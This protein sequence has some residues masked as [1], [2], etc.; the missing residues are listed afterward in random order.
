MPNT[1]ISDT[2]LYKDRTRILK[3]REG[4]GRGSSGQESIAHARDGGESDIRE[5]EALVV[6]KGGL[7]GVQKERRWWFLGRI[8]N[9]LDV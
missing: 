5:R 4:K 6:R 9:I 7:V 8:R 1:S 3:R 2:K